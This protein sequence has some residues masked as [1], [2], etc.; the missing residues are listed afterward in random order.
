MLDG[1]RLARRREVV[2]SYSCV[3]LGLVTGGDGSCTGHVVLPGC[4]CYLDICLFA[5]A[6][7]TLGSGTLGIGVALIVGIHVGEDLTETVLRSSLVRFCIWICSFMFS[8]W[9]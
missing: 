9:T 3:G 8:C 7:A 1:G 6:T 5:A 4:Y 2:G